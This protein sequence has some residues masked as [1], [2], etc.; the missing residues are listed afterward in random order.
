MC[1]VRFPVI[2]TELNNIEKRYSEMLAR[3]EFENSMLSD[4]EL[5]HMQDLA[6]RKKRMENPTHEDFDEDVGTSTAQDF[7]D[8]GV[9]EF[10]NFTV[11]PRTTEADNTNNR[12][13][14]KR[15]LDRKLFL[16]VKQKLGKN[17]E[18]VFPMGAN[19]DGQSLRE[20][21]VATLSSTCGEDVKAQVNGN[22]PVGFYKYKLP[23]G[24]ATTDGYFGAKIFFYQ[25][26]FLGGVPKNGNGIVD[27]LWLTQEEMAQLLNRKY[28]SAISNFIFE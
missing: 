25:A 13:S 6:R 12:R 18:W 24:S 22:A 3:V 7:E 27:H 8:A 10:Q 2:S 4:F 19:K 11:T 21:A 1:V 5:W 28:F 20:T 15:K 9:E 16:V 14:L 17:E 26:Q 23:S